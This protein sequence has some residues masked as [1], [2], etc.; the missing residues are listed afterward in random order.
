MD[1]RESSIAEVRGIEAAFDVSEALQAYIAKTSV[2][3]L[4]TSF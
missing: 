4:R 1:F 3:S 2:K